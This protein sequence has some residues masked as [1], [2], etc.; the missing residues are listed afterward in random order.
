[1]KKLLCLLTML[2]FTTL[3]FAQDIFYLRAEA[4]QAGKKN[5]YKEIIWDESTQTSCDILI[6]LEETKAVIYSK[7]TQVYHVISYKGKENGVS[8]WF[9][10]DAE[11]RKCNIYLTYLEE[12]PD[13]LGV[14]VEFSDYAWFYVCRKN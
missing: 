12:Y 2:L 5:Y 7:E 13:K 6:K 11:G 4:F 9:C 10:S 8:K 1:M 3:S 14:V